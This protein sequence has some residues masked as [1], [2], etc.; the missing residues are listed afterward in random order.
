MV[1]S[2]FRHLCFVSHPWTSLPHAAPTNLLSAWWHKQ[3]SYINFTN[4]ALGL[5]YA[6][7]AWCLG[8]ECP[9]MVVVW[10]MGGFGLNTVGAKPPLTQQCRVHIGFLSTPW[11]AD[12]IVESQPAVTGSMP[13]LGGWHRVSCIGAGGWATTLP[14]KTL[15]NAKT[16]VWPVAAW[17]K[18]C[19]TGSGQHLT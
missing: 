12:Y 15:A 9:A 1:C 19:C 10:P 18:A 5:W 4:Y 7:G 17:H 3:V 14:G 11:C 16:T 8:A 2:Q 6:A 13:P